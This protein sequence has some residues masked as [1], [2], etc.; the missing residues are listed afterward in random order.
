MPHGPET[1]FG[2]LP[3]PQPLG[4]GRCATWRRDPEHLI[5]RHKEPR[6]NPE[7]VL[8]GAVYARGLSLQ[9]PLEESVCGR[10]CAAQKLDGGLPLRSDMLLLT[11]CGARLRLRSMPLSCQD[12]LPRVPTNPLVLGVLFPGPGASNGSHMG[13]ASPG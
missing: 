6:R 7:Q 1:V 12:G 5:R 10:S 2:V 9:Q 11:S 8:Q 4:W 3:S 13:S